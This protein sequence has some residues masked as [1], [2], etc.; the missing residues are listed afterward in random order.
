[1]KAQRRT[2]VIVIAVSMLLFFL[3]GEAY[4]TLYCNRPYAQLKRDPGKPYNAVGLLNNGCTAFLIDANH[5]VA[6][7]HCF[8]N[9]STGQWQNGL[10]F[11]PNFHPSRV[12]ADEL[13]V[14]RADVL[15]VVVGSRAG[16][17]VLG[18]GM[19]WGI[20]RVGNWKDTVGL[21]LTPVALASYIPPLGAPLVNPAYTRHHFP[22]ND[23]SGAKWDN[24]V[25]DT[26][27]CG[28]VQPNNGMWAIKM[29]K[30]P[31]Y[32]GVNRDTVGCNSRWGAGY[33]HANCALANI[34][35]DVVI[36]NCDSIGGSSGSP[37]MYL[38]NTGR[39]NVVAVGHGGGSSA[40]ASSNN[41]GLLTPTC[42]PD[43]PSN[44][45]N[46]GASVER[47][48]NAPRFASNVAV[49]RSPSNA[50]ATAVFAVDSDL[51]HVVYRTRIGTPPTYS[52][53]FTYWQSLGTPFSGAKLSRIAACSADA[54]GKPQVF[55]VVNKRQ[56]YTRSA[57]AMGQWSAWS[58]FS[59]PA[60]TNG[61][62]DL[63]TT[64]DSNG[65]CLLLIV[66]RK[67]GGAFARFK[68][69]DTTWGKWEKMAS[70]SFKAITALNY[71][72]TVWAALLQSGEIWR[73]SLGTT[74]WTAPI[75][76]NR[77]AQIA[78]WRDIDL[79][80]DEAARGF[81]LAIP[82]SWNG[83]APSPTNTLWFTPLYGSQPWIEWRYFE[84]HL[85]A[86]G[87]SPQNPPTLQS[88]TASRWMEDSGGTTSPVIFGTDDKG[89]V[90]LVEYAR[91][92][93]VGWNLNWKS[94]YHE[95]IP[96]P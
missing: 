35:N 71:A 86:P 22:Y 18:D 8:E 36:H 14:P 25:W 29:R 57:N 91:V 31:I 3:V 38:D 52:S 1:M 92:G 70:G 44:A 15:S 37:S 26:T 95:Y 39:W 12:R 46:T 32:D 82:A 56:I 63:D 24:M 4:A 94:F 51:D 69:S 61:V 66:T 48:R 54:L 47:F 60:Q 88:I 9:T 21:D 58:S 16:E 6:A 96:Y 76:L 78:A 81:M 73:T 34:V 64:T 74:G 5:I 10:R 17:N 77:P 40:T 80:W 7:A 75:K 83:V 27:Y 50:S 2:I 20:A 43:T 11:Y 65:R 33:I 90:Y 30:A 13:H 41:F 28:W 93:A 84:N 62:V 19:D 87:A 72:G 49:H 45:D 68:T 55:V 53:K 59:I 89:N 85:W 42:S 79:T 67:G 23:N